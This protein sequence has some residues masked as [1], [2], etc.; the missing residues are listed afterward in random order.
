MLWCSWNNA[1]GIL[2]WLLSL[3]STYLY[4]RVQ[5]A[6]EQ[7]FVLSLDVHEVNLRAAHYYSGKRGLGGSQALYKEP[8]FTIIFHMDYHCPQQSSTRVKICW[9]SCTKGRLSNVASMIS[10]FVNVED[11]YDE[12]WVEP[13][14]II[15]MQTELISRSCATGIVAG[16]HHSMGE[17]SIAVTILQSTEKGWKSWKC[18]CN[19]LIYS[20]QL[21]FKSM[22]ML[23][24][25]TRC[26]GPL[27]F[28]LHTFV[29]SLCQVCRYTL[30]TFHCKQ[31]LWSLNGF[32]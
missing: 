5:W 6:A 14:I 26:L 2:R 27:S 9:L 18:F 8:G 13:H 24:R 20:Q 7:F 19:D 28:Y 15:F 10:R 1:W 11:K 4:C 17:Y 32:L 16:C 31:K 21:I 23:H 29:E 12:G 22:Q 25:I 30:H 3:V